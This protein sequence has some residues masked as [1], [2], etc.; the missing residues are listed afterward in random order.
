MAASDIYEIVRGTAS[1]VL[2]E[3]A[4]ND[5]LSEHREMRACLRDLCSA[6]DAHWQAGNPVTGSVSSAYRWARAV[7]AEV[8]ER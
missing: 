4:I 1:E 3:A 6:L 7:L 8:E 2:R 5:I